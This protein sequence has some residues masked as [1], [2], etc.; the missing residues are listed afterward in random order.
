MSSEQYR[1][2]PRRIP[3]GYLAATLALG[4]VAGL[5]LQAT[6]D[7][8]AIADP[9]GDTFG[10]GTTRIDITGFSAAHAGDELV[11][12]LTFG[13]QVSP[14]DSG[15]DDALTGFVDLDVDRDPTTGGRP[16]VD[17]VTG[18]ATGMG[19]D[20]YVP[21]D[22]FNSGDGM[23]DLVDDSAV[24]IGRVSVIFSANGM[25]LRIPHALLG[26]GGVVHSAAVVGTLGEANDTVP[27][28]GFIASDGLP[29]GEPVLLNGD[30]FRVDL[31]WRNFEGGG[32]SGQLAVRSDDSAVFYFFDPLNWEVLVKVLDACH[33]NGF[34]WVFAA[35]TTNLE[36]T[37]TVT[38]TETGA[39]KQYSNPLG[40][41]S[42]AVTDTGAFATC[43]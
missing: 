34:Y 37:L 11:I 29:M 18:F 15:R 17:F 28:G 9:T 27:D 8:G 35:A 24:V 32:G 12:D 7:K 40:T 4:L 10:T 3:A 31:V 41:P 21:L 25:S 5:A 26:S 14:P 20:L 30:R 39:V 2:R 13:G 43:P 16:L 1:H 22:S 36:Y 42:P 6:P 19:T 33:V 38:D 23:V